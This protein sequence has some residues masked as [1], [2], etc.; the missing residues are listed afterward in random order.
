MVEQRE[1]ERVAARLGEAAGAER[2]ILFG[3]YAGGNA[4]E[5][6]DV[7]LMIVAPSDLPRFKRSRALY[8]LFVRI[9]FRWI[10]WCIR[11]RRWSGGGS[12]RYPLCQRCCGK[13]RPFMS[14]EPMFTTHRLILV[15]FVSDPVD[16]MQRI[17]QVASP[18]ILVAES[19]LPDGPLN[20][21]FL[22][23]VMESDAVTEVAID[24]SQIVP[25]HE[26]SVAETGS[27]LSASIRSPTCEPTTS[28]S[29][30]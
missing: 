28:L 26:R 6:S 21:V 3:S 9:R 15:Q 27:S 12:R 8:R 19:P 17:E 1:I 30:R 22:S 13:G 7:D 24:I 2:V 20:P 4:R 25:E 29:R 11:P 5:Q 10:S 14:E 23:Q 18:M 16:G